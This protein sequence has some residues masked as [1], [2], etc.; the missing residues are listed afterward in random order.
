M[1]PRYSSFFCCQ[2]LLLSFIQ[3]P[4]Q[5]LQALQSWNL[6]GLPLVTKMIA[7]VPIRGSSV[8]NAPP[9]RDWI[10][11][12]LPTAVAHAI[13]TR[14]N[15]PLYRPSATIRNAKAKTASALKGTH[16]TVLAK[17]HALRV[18]NSLSA[19]TTPDV[20]EKMA[21]VPL[22]TMMGVNVRQ[23]IAPKSGTHHTAASVETKVGTASA[24]VYPR[25][26]TSGRV[27]HAWI[28]RKLMF[29]RQRSPIRITEILYQRFLQALIRTPETIRSY[30]RA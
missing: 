6:R 25:R 23:K 14:R 4:V 28:Q 5:T 16:H 26:A 18:I 13:E 15:V 2:T 27:A 20:E 8:S 10:F 12:S 19:T 17:N 1:V 7:H 21:N 24:W 30:V 11:A 9:C 3:A 22:A 29:T